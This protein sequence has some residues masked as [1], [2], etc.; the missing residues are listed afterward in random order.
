MHF[1]GKENGFTTKILSLIIT[2]S[3][4]PPMHIK[5]LMVKFLQGNKN[6]ANMDWTGLNF[7][8]EKKNNTGLR[9][10]PKEKTHPLQTHII[11]T[12]SIYRCKKTIYNQFIKK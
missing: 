5:T 7:K 6:Q 11:I 4:E 10:V 3:H 2:F 8:F 1:V 9:G 12:C